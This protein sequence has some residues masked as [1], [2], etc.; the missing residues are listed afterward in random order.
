MPAASLFKFTTNVSIHEI[1]AKQIIP[2]LRCV[3]SQLDL[4]IQSKTDILS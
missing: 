3:A 4:Q 1:L 2:H